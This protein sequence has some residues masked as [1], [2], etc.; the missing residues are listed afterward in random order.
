MD[1]RAEAL[2]A[3]L[4][5]MEMRRLDELETAFVCTPPPQPSWLTVAGVETL[6]I[7]AQL[8]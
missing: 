6:V 5:P 2:K 7:Q 4:W 8:F 3:K 1:E